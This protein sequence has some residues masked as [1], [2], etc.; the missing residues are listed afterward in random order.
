[1]SILGWLVLGG[2]AGFITSKVMKL[3]AAAYIG[4]IALGVAGEFIGGWVCLFLGAGDLKD[5]NSYSML[6][7]VACL[8]GF[9]Q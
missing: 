8:A 9:G 1:M 4:D 7:A 5:F 2:I 6:G 3:E